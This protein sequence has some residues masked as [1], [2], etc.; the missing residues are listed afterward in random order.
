MSKSMVEG[1]GVP[2]PAGGLPGLLAGYDPGPFFCELTTPRPDGGREVRLIAERLVGLGVEEL[3]RRAH[4]VERNLYDLGVTFTVYS[5][6]SAI[7]RILP[8]D[9][10]PRVLFAAEWAHIE[11]G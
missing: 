5:D 6:A 2:E 8:F 9:L 1:S 7:D 4:Q 3:R 10:V 11:A